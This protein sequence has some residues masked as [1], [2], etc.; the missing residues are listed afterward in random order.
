MP[1]NVKNKIAIITGSAQG[2][3]K[4]FARRIL[5]KGGKVCLSDINIE[6]GEKTMNEYS[7]VYGK[8]FVTFKRC[9]IEFSIIIS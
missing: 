6:N 2:F 3:G 4:E 9:R 8:E 7:E 5:E 1:F